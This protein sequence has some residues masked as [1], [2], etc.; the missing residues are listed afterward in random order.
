MIACPGFLLQRGTRRGEFRLPTLEG[1]LLD[2]RTP[3]VALTH[4]ICR[5]LTEA[6]EVVPGKGPR[7]SSDLIVLLERAGKT[8]IVHRL[9]RGGILAPANSQLSAWTCSEEGERGSA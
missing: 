3:F 8:C 6:K 5:R 7:G 4:R 1:A 9:R 2:C